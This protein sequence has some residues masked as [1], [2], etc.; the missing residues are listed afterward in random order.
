MASRVLVKESLIIIGYSQS[1]ALA[2]AE[3]NGDNASARHTEAISR[4]VFDLLYKNMHHDIKA[5][6]AQRLNSIHDLIQFTIENAEKKYKPEVIAEYVEL[7]KL[8]LSRLMTVVNEWP[9]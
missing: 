5:D 8:N 9:A 7:Q 4:L 2:L 6:A 3:Q 1:A